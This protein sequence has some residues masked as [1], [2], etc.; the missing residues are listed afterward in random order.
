MI[1]IEY[2]PERYSIKATGHANYAPYGQDIVCAA[3]ST[4]IQTLALCIEGY[5]SGLYEEPTIIIGENTEISCKPLPE[6]EREISL[7]YWYC[8]CGLDCLAERYP[9]NIGITTLWHQGANHTESQ[10]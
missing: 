7:L 8:I 10:A 4:L 1:I 3:A 5:S 2:C 9:K 6:R